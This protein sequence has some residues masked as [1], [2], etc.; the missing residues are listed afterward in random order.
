MKH[1]NQNIVSGSIDTEARITSLD[2]V[3]RLKSTGIVETQKRSLDS[4]IARVIQSRN[5][6]HFARGVKRERT[7]TCT[8]RSLFHVVEMKI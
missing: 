2:V 6:V 1:P 4:K 7:P 8:T 5:L 3:P